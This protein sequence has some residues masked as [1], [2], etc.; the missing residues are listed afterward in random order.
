MSEKTVELTPIMS[1]L[2]LNGSATNFSVRGHLQAA[3]DF[4][5]AVASQKEIDNSQISFRKSQGGYAMVTASSNP[6]QGYQSYYLVARSEKP[7]AARFWVEAQP[8]LAISVAAPAPAK[9]RNLSGLVW[10][11]LLVIVVLMVAKRSK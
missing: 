2:D 4:E 6:G 5:Y 3:E 8:D 1:L 9:P 7:L 10:I 11:A